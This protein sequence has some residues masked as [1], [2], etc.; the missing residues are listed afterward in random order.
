MIGEHRYT[1]TMLILETLF[2]ILK[3]MTD[4]KFKRET[5]FSKAE[6]YFICQLIPHS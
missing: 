4:D 3:W 2:A 6:K 1:H 5:Q